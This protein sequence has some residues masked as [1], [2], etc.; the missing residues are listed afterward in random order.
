MEFVAPGRTLGVIDRCRAVS[1]AVADYVA[2]VTVAVA[3]SLRAEG[4]ALPAGTTDEGA[5]GVLVDVL[6]LLDG[7]DL[8]G[9]APELVQ[10]RPLLERA[11]ARARERVGT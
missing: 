2:S 9:F 4:V 1:A 6:A 10:H 8:G 5:R 3:V 7:T 11:L